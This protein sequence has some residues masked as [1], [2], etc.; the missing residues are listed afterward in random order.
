MC[1]VVTTSDHKFLRT[2]SLARIVFYISAGYILYRSRSHE[3]VQKAGGPVAGAARG[4]C[5]SASARHAEHYFTHHVLKRM[6]Q[7]QITMPCVVEVLRQGHMKR[8]AEPD[9]KTGNLVCRLDRY[10][11]GRDIGV[12][13]AIDD[14]NPYLIVVTAMA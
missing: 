14:D 1:R 2:I 5:P 10:V 3:K 4:I 7:R 8:P 12:V 9:I 6:K 13:L 11:A